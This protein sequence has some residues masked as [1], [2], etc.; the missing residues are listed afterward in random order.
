M[1][2]SSNEKQERF[3]GTY[4]DRDG[5]LR[6]SRLAELASWVILTIYLLTLIFSVLLFSRSILMV[7]T[8]QKGASRF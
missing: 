7:Y 1:S 2:E 6:L 8:L 3:L 5:V 4:F